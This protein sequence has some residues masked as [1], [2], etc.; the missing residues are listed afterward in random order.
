MHSSKQKVERVDYSLNPLLL[1]SNLDLV[2]DE[3]HNFITTYNLPVVSVGSGHC[4]FEQ[5]YLNKY[6]LKNEIICVDPSPMHWYSDRALID[7]FCKNDFINVASLL[8]TRKNI[9]DNCVVLL[10]W[11]YPDGDSYDLQAI[12]DLNPQ[13][14]FVMAAD[15]AKIKIMHDK[16]IYNSNAGTPKFHAFIKNDGPYRKIKRI[17]FENTNLFI[18]WFT[19]QDNKIQQLSDET[20]K[21]LFYDID[22][23]ITLKQEHKFYKSIKNEQPQFAA[24]A[25]AEPALT[26]DHIDKMSVKD[27]KKQLDKKDVNYSGFVEKSEF[28]NALKQSLGLLGG[29]LNNWF[30]HCY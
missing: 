27:L 22:V 7:K 28:I 12:L 29:Y 30:H 3:F 11:S 10:N 16:Q 6:G 19:R 14:F 18:A 13:G 8:E 5:L 9:K 26:S 2:I 23:G 15:P 25:A 17:D 24:A 20:I 21:P 1:R 4:C